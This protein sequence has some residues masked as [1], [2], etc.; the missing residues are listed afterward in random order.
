MGKQR[1]R[2]FGLD[3][4]REKEEDILEATPEFRTRKG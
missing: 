1:E 4:R 2:T 3:R